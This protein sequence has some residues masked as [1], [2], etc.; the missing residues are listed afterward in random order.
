MLTNV[1]K[2]K[3]EKHVKLHINSE[4]QSFTAIC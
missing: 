3:D 4:K 2:N 1:I